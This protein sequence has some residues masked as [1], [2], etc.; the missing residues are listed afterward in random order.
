MT[1]R[2]IVFVIGSL[3]RG[4]AERQLVALSEAVRSRGWD[5]WILC[6]NTGGNPD[7]LERV[8]RAGVV[9]EELDLG[10]PR[11]ERARGWDLLRLVHGYRFL[12]S[13]PSPRRLLLHV[14]EL[15][16]VRA[17]RE[18]RARAGRRDLPAEP[19]GHGGRVALAPARSPARRPAR[20]RRGLR[21]SSGEVGC[22]PQRRDAAAQDRGDPE[23]CRR[24]GQV[25]APPN[26]ERIGIACIANLHPYK[27]HTVLLEAFALAERR[28]GSGRLHLEL[29]GSGVEHARLV[30]QAE[31][32]GVTDR[33]A[34]LGTVDDVEGRSGHRRSRCSRRSARDSRCR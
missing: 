28:L 17:D 30:E 1:G 34:F 13:G 9:V 2:R 27:G 29:V 11:S 7:W 5:V 8:R 12:R 10:R 19:V 33:V 23:R 20:R 6:L 26:G 15:H 3:R 31:R 21:V 25:D 24:A 32:L 22:D 16:A 4:G 18:A 14:V